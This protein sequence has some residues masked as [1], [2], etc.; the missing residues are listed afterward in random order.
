M[1]SVLSVYLE[2]FCR[3][4]YDS[5]RNA[6]K[7]LTI[8]D[9]FSRAPTEN[10]SQTRRNIHQPIRSQPVSADNKKGVKSTLAVLCFFNGI[11]LLCGM[12][13]F[14]YLVLRSFRRFFL[15]LAGNDS[16]S[17]DAWS[18][19]QTVL[20]YAFNF[21]WL[22]P[23]FIISKF[24][25]L[26][27][28]RDTAYIVFQRL[29]KKKTTLQ[30]LDFSHALSD[31]WFSLV[32]QIFFLIQSTVILSIPI[33]VVF[34]FFGNMCLCLL[35]SFYAFEYSWIYRN[36]NVANRIRLID[37]HWPYFLGFGLPLTVIST[38]LSQSMIINEC[39]FS[40]L[41][42]FAIVAATSISYRERIVLPPESPSIVKLNVFAPSI[43]VTNYLFNL[44][45]KRSKSV[46]ETMEPPSGSNAHF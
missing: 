21:L 14:E 28:F 32:M 2:L 43:C 1:S 31:G 20:K 10:N 6:F 9:D 19:V 13:C 35:Y 34:T 15:A 29:T 36:I 24:V 11:I 27:L 40:M 30:K 41:F 37:N 26:F 22:I 7:I 45:P 38:Q 17:T 39:I 25:N 12:I 18:F 46:K 5:V 3:G 8:D 44:I 16:S 4:L 42:P 33:P 23:A